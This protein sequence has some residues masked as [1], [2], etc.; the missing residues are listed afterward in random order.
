MEDN[1][2]DRLIHQY[3]NYTKQESEIA[4]YILTHKNSVPYMSISEMATACNV[5]A[6]TITRFVQKLGY[7]GFKELK[8][9]SIKSNRINV[10]TDKKYSDEDNY[11]IIYSDDPIDVKCTKLYKIDSAAISQTIEMMDYAVLSSVVDL[12]CSANNVYCFGQGNSA[13]TA[14]EMWGRFLTV[15]SKYHYVSNS[16]MQAYTAAHCEKGDVIVYFSYSGATR[17]LIE[18]GN[19]LSDKDA[20]LVLITR[21]P[22]SPGAELADYVLMCGVHEASYR[23]GSIAARIAQ[24]FIIDVLYNE[25]YMRNKCESEKNNLR[26]MDTTLSMIL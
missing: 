3:S 26:M 9:E 2:F 21:Y 6:A 18:I 1:L 25:Y 17:E 20:K 16:H 13:I 8:V 24:L 14:Q 7:S 11:S 5:G 22:N 10:A 23:Q 15:S 19:S 4:D 12:L